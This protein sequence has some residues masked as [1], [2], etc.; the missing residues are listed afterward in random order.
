MTTPTA[1]RLGIIKVSASISGSYTQMADVNSIDA[2][3]WHVPSMMD[4]TRCGDAAGRKAS[5]GFYQNKLTISGNYDA[6][7]AGMAIFLTNKALGT[8]GVQYL[9][10][11]SAGYKQEM[12]ATAFDLK[13]APGSDA[14][15]FTITLESANGTAPVAAP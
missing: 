13:P 7:E 4:L 5:S 11:G 8:M 12:I 6:A 3:G 1:G 9:P 14:L 10:D 2:S 15:K